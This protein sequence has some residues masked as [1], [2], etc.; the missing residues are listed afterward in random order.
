MNEC[1]VKFDT[2]GSITTKKKKEKCDVY[3]PDA[4]SLRVAQH[5]FKHFQSSNFDVQD[6]PRSDRPVTDKVVAILE[7]VEQ[8]RHISSY[9]IAEQLGIDHKTVLNHLTKT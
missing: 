9:D 2:F 5:C 3:G 8:D 4:V 6:E 7:K 1:N